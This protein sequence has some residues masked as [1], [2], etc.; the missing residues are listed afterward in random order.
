MNWQLVVE[1]LGIDNRLNIG[2]SINRPIGNYRN[3][4]L[5]SYSLDLKK[6][7]EGDE[8]MVSLIVAF[9]SYVFVDKKGV[10][11]QF[12]QQVNHQKSHFC[13]FFLSD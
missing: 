11:S 10:L 7:S 6:V 3:M 5:K 2:S 8:K 4:G 13:F 1:S 12:Q 9:N